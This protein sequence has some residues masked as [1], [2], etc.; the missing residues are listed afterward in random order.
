MVNELVLFLL[1]VAWKTAIALCYFPSVITRRVL[2]LPVQ[3]LMPGAVSGRDGVQFLFLL[4]ALVLAQLP[5]ST[6]ISA[7][8]SNTFHASHSAIQDEMPRI[9]G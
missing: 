6:Q 4:G 3:R 1:I 9:T 2:I 5:L 8:V 7:H